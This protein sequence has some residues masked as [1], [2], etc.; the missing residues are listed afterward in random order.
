MDIIPP[1]KKSE[2]HKKRHIQQ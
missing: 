1:A 2:V